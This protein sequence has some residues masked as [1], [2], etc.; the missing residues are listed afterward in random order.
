MGLETDQVVEKPAPVL[1][2][3]GRAAASCGCGC[4]QQLQQSAPPAAQHHTILARQRS[5]TPAWELS[6]LVTAWHR[7]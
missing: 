2:T 1:S 5:N 6:I 4:Q 7:C 3:L